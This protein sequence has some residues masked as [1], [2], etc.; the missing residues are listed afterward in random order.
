MNSPSSTGYGSINGS[1][2]ISSDYTKPASVS[3]SQ[4]LE[5]LVVKTSQL[6]YLFKIVVFQYVLKVEDS[7]A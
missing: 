7:F 4:I 3:D 5:Y 6:T 1:R 2:N